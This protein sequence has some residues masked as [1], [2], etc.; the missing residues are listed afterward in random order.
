[1]L[2]GTAQYLPLIFAV[3]S[4][5][6]MNSVCARLDRRRHVLQP[7][8]R[9]ELRGPDHVHAEHVALGRLRLL[10]LDE[11]RALLVGRRRQLEQLH[12]HARVRLVVE[13]RRP[14]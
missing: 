3:F 12:V 5:D 14:G 11:L 7:A 13:A 4:V 1:M 2:N 8:L 9:R 6:G 10:A